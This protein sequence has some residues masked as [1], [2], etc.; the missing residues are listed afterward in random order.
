MHRLH[1]H[2]LF[3]LFEGLIHSVWSLSITGASG[4]LQSGTRQRPVRQ[5]IHDFAQSGAAWD[6]FILALGR[7]QDAST[8]DVL[9]YFQVAAIH[10]YPARP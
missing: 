7:F 8:T 10:G 4:G 5:E 9:S 6:L 3:V 2:L 1:F